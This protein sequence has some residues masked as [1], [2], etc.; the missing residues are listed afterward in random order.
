MM[1]ESGIPDDTPE[2]KVRFLNEILEEEC[3]KLGLKACVKEEQKEFER[4][5]R[6]DVISGERSFCRWCPSITVS[7]Q[8]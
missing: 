6:L 3:K 4:D 5:V 2:N 8:S 1:V 7:R